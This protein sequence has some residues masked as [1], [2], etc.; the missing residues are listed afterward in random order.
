LSYVDKLLEEFGNRMVVEL[1]ND[2]VI[3]HNFGNNCIYL[4]LI[5]LAVFVFGILVQLLAKLAC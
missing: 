1:K 4:C 2:A 5:Y 3:L